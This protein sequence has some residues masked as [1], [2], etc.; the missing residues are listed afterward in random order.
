[1]SIP[2]GN[3]ASTYLN[4]MSHLH[5]IDKRLISAM[6]HV[7]KRSHTRQA[8]PDQGND[9]PLIRK[10]VQT[11][12]MRGI[13]EDLNHGISSPMFRLLL[14]KRALYCMLI[15]LLSSDSTFWFMIVCFLPFLNVRVQTKSTVVTVPTF[16]FRVNGSYVN[17][18]W[19]NWDTRR[20][21][22]ISHPVSRKC[23]YLNFHAYQLQQEWWVFIYHICRLL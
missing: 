16:D 1:M 6:L 8:V 15:Y 17:L 19:Q 21:I 22:W 3:M 10:F 23:F 12:P 5:Y 13:H 9:P 2:V 20:N 18:S 11:H 14:T 7:W 4:V